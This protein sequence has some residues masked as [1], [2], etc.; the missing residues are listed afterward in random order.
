MKFK[1]INWIK[2]ANW[3]GALIQDTNGKQFLTS[4]IY[5]W[6][7]EPHREYEIVDAIDENK[8]FKYWNTHYPYCTLETKN[9]LRCTYSN[10]DSIITSINGTLQDAENY[11]LGQVFNIGSVND[12]IQ[13]CV[14]VELVK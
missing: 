7:L 8:F 10:G 2:T 9:T 12:N 1:L 3:E 5:K 6:T 13:Q 14:K 4:G 11:F